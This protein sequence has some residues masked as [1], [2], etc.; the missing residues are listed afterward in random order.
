MK[1]LAR[2]KW[3]CRRGMRELDFLLGRYLEQ[4]YPDAGP[5]E[6]AGFEKFLELPDPVILSWVTGK[7]QPPEGVFSEII[8]QLLQQPAT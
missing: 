3:R 7:E 4:H 6:R 5:E 8:G 2:V 1:D